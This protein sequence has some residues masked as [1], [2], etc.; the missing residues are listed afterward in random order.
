MVVL[1]T[2]FVSFSRQDEKINIY[3]FDR[4]NS[5]KYNLVDNGV[6]FYLLAYKQAYIW[7]DEGFQGVKQEALR[8]EIGSYVAD[9][10]YP[11]EQDN[12]GCINGPYGYHIRRVYFK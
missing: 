3:K 12:E 4:H 7:T 5:E 8:P 2:D 1:C 11:C 10:S 9:Y 6:K